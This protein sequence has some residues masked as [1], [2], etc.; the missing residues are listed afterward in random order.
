M[1][2]PPRCVSPL[3][4]ST[5]N[6]P[7]STLQD[8]DVEGAAAE[9]VDGDDAGAP[10]VEAVGERRRGRLVD[11]PQHL[12]AGDA[13]GVAGGGALRVVEVRGHGDDRRGRLR[14]RT[15]LLGEER[16]GPVLQL[17]ED[18]RGDLGR[19][20]F[21]VAEP[22]ADDAAGFAADPEREMFGL[23]LHVLAAL[24][25]EPLH[26]VGGAAR[27]GQQAAL[28]LPP[29][30]DLPVVADRDDRRDQAVAARDRG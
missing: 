29:D 19:R 21:A 26:R 2:S 20:E 15:R 8:R 16:L 14:C 5:W 30:M 25:H 27:V 23:V 3:V 28:R 1:S 18:E 22:D 24:A 11:D 12:E 13:A 4:E 7:S 6:T 17:A 9:V 10:L